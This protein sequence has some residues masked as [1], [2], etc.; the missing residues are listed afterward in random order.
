MVTTTSRIRA[1]A[2]GPP[3]AAAHGPDWRGA[4][5]QSSWAASCK[6]STAVRNASGAG[7]GR[8]PPG[9]KSYAKHQI[10]ETA[11]WHHL[12]LSGEVDGER[13]PAI[14]QGPGVGASSHYLERLRLQR[15]G[16]LDEDEAD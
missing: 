12:I 9:S 8:A 1:S 10:A 15:H 3:D 14:F 11:H 5:G 6:H 2:R 13:S 4:A 16:L 7:I